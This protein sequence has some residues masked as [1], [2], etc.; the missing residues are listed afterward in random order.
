MDCL[1]RH[2]IMFNEPNICESPSTIDTLKML[3]G[4]D[5]CPVAIKMQAPSVIRHIPAI[6]G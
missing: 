6:N 2:V 4:A 1:D 5:L 3:F